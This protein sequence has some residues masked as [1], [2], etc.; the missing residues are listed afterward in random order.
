[1]SSRRA[2][3]AASMGYGRR[4]DV[5]TESMPKAKESAETVVKRIRE[6]GDSGEAL[7]KLGCELA[8]PG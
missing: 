5:L 1:M 3:T 8:V 6:A 7:E 2:S 4:D